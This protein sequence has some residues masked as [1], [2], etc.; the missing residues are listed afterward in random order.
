MR[1]GSRLNERTLVSGAAGESKRPRPMAPPTTRS[2]SS[3]TRASATMAATRTSMRRKSSLE[4]TRVELLR[5][6]AL[7]HATRASSGVQTLA[8]P[9]EGNH[10]VEHNNPTTGDVSP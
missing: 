1:V 9:T 8:D 2:R 10:Q 4:S 6:A 7:C 5:L 3:D